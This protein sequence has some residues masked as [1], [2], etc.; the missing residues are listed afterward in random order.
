MAA[1][2]THLAANSLHPFPLTLQKTEPQIC[3][4]RKA[5]KRLFRKRHKVFVVGQNKT[6]TTSM[7]LALEQLGYKLG[8]QIEAELLFD[9]WLDGRFDRIIDLCRQADAFQ[10]VP[11]SLKHTYRKLDQEYPGSKF[12]LTERQDADEWFESLARFHTK[13][14]GKNRLPT[15][16]DLAD[17]P[18]RAEGWFLKA[19]LAIFDVTEDQLYD[20]EHYIAHYESHNKE[21]KD[22]F[23]GRSNDFLSLNVADTDAAAKLC[24]FLGVP[25]RLKTMPH[26]NQSKS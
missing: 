21:L 9:D 6:G 12:I 14:I 17:F 23:K 4:V 11:F 26:A 16:E 7:A 22:Y 19:H 8:D 5:L 24:S 20:R 18:Y 15:L 10:D 25:G 1:W 13:I 2:Q 3:A